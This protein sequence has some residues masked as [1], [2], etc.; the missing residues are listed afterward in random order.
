MLVR[1]RC[2]EA[3]DIQIH[4]STSFLD[5]VPVGDSYMIL[6][7]GE[8]HDMRVDAD[9]G[10]VWA[11]KKPRSKGCWKG[12]PYRNADTVLVKKSGNGLEFVNYTTVKNKWDGIRQKAATSANAV[13]PGIE[14]ASLLLSALVTGIAATGTKGALPSGMMLG[15]GSLLL[16]GLG[17]ATESG[18][19]PP[20][21]DLSEIES[22]VRDIVEQALD[23][24]SAKDHANRLIE[25]S[26]ML[27]ESG[28]TAH[29]Q[30][31]GRSDMGKLFEL[32]P[33]DYWDFR[34]ANEDYQKSTG[35]FWNSLTTL[36]NNPD[37]ARFVLPALFAGISARLQIWRIHD[38]IRH[39]D[40][41]RITSEDL[42][43]FVKQI[44]RGIESLTAAT[45]SLRN[46]VLAD[47]DKEGVPR[48]SP[49][50]NELTR[51]M[52]F[53]YTGSD[54]LDFADTALKQL[55]H[56]K[57]LVVED[58]ASLKSGGGMKHY[59]KAEW[60]AAERAPVPKRPGM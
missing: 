18:E 6:Q 16:M 29:S 30:L 35:E 10:Y 56:L 54:S 57:E 12:G 38:F 48:P 4:N 8:D 39:L 2:G 26:F 55:G 23:E 47:I 51:T 27:I 7:N 13:E 50:A 43:K 3:L 37:I 24:H 44:D 42:D 58:L 17:V 45:D 49:E 15:I 9:P 59:W 19:L 34:D 5:I 52:T 21:P 36:Y 60:D 31:L 22:A 41:G 20:P 33:H 40:G 11:Y 1:N 32:S 25:A 46:K 28:G 53:R 14:I